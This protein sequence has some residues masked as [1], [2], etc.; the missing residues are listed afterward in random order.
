MFPDLSSPIK[1]QD[2]AVARKGKKTPEDLQL[3][4]RE[5]DWHE[6][7]WIINFN[8]G[9]WAESYKKSIT[10]LKADFHFFPG[11]ALS[12]LSHLDLLLVRVLVCCGPQTSRT[13]AGILRQCCIIS[14]QN[15]RLQLPPGMKRK[16]SQELPVPG[17]TLFLQAWVVC[18]Y[19]S[20]QA[21]LG[22]WVCTRKQ[23]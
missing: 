22:F 5:E 14:L 6:Q 23:K 16:K 18:L 21:H 2:Q 11:M 4:R 13:S 1:S 7:L 19:W 3:L 20:L 8:L 15:S 17:I 9:M 10:V 12:G